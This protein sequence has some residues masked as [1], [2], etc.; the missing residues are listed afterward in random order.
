MILLLL[1]SI[2]LHQASSTPISFSFSSFNNDSCTF[3]SLICT[4][5]VT[6]HNGYLSLTSDPLPGNSTSSS[7][8]QPLNKVGRV[9]Y[10]QP[11]LAWPATISTTFTIRILP[12]ANSSGWADGLTFI[13]A[14][15]TRPS[16]PYSYGSYLGLADKSFTGIS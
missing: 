4:G 15:D 9:L 13:F 6:P 11:V 12:Y 1:V 8:S 5:S 16:P 14:P 7:P 3:G 2:F 10:N